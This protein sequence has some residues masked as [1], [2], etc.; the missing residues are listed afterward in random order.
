MAIITITTDLGVKD[1]YLASVKGSIYN[2]INDVTIVDISNTIQPFNIQEAAY[3]LRNCFKDF[4]LGSVHII[5]VDDEIS[6]DVGA[7]LSST[8]SIIML[9]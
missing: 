9:T 7:T 3:T 5:S 4:P 1:S 2:Q 8:T 6:I